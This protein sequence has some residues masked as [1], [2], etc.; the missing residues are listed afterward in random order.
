[1]ASIKGFLFVNKNKRQTIKMYCY[2]A[3]YRFLM[4]RLPKEMLESKIGIR[5]EES[6]EEEDMVNMREAY[7][8]GKEVMRISEKTPW[9]SKCLVRALTARKI[10]SEKGI[11]TTLYLGVGKEDGKMVA[12]S[13]L[14]CGTIYVTGGNGEG[15]AMVAKFLCK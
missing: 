14:R 7:H 1:M 15:Y 11:S 10:L 5:G 12:H 8:I 9:E 3:Y 4:I 13:W 2:M 6:P